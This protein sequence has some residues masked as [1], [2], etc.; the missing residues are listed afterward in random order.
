MVKKRNDS[1]RTNDEKSNTGILRSDT[2]V[3]PFSIWRIGE[4]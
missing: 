3:S 4:S 1:V 2:R